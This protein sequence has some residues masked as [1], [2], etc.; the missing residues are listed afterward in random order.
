MADKST[1]Q[2]DL[3]CKYESIGGIHIEDLKHQ[4]D[5]LQGCQDDDM[6]A[7]NYITGRISQMDDDMTTNALVQEREARVID[8]SMRQHSMDQLKTEI[9]SCE[10]KIAERKKLAAEYSTGISPLTS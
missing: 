8:L 9:N 10:Q 5:G 2:Y 3:V 1:R 6:R 4:Y 7:I